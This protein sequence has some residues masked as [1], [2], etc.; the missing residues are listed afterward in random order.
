MTNTAAKPATVTK[1][2][3]TPNMENFKVSLSYEGLSIK[4]SNEGKIDHSVKSRPI[5]AINMGLIRTNTA[6]KIP[7]F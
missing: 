5:C 4:K 1:L 6:T 7:R 2:K 3:F